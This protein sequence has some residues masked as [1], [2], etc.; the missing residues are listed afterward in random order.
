ME[1]FMIKE[2]KYSYEINREKSLGRLRTSKD[3]YRIILPFYGDDI[4]FYE[5][6]K[7]ILIDRANEVIGVKTIS[8]GGI[9]GTSADPKKV[10]G[11]ALV[12]Q[13]SSVILV[14]NHPSGNLQP[15]SADIQFT[16]KIKAA[17]KYLELPVLDHLVISDQGYY[18]F[19]DEGLI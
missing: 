7:I 18:S 15:S 2:L 19:A 11:H 8:I 3:G 12:A 14:H 5:S 13:A 4:A 17:G 9:A 16:N 6:L 1:D 10:F